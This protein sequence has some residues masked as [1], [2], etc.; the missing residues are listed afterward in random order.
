M[1]KSYS[2]QIREALSVGFKGW[3]F[4]YILESGRM[5]EE[6][7]D[8][9]YEKIVR[10]YFTRTATML[11]MGT[12]GG[13]VLSSL[14]LLPQKTYATESYVPNVEVARNKLEPLGVEVLYIPEN[15]IP[16]YS[17][18][19]P[20]EK[21]YFDLVINRHD[22]YYPKELY[23]ILKDDGYFI[24]Q[25]VGFLTVANLLKDMLGAN[26]S[27]G[28]WNLQSATDELQSEK[29]N[30]VQQNEQISF[31]RFY[32]IGAFVYYL[33]AIPWLVED[34]TP[35]K[36]DKQL[37]YIHQIIQNQGYYQTLAHRFFIIAKKS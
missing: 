4:S 31:I 26:A 32:D 14:M 6:G 8:W 35:E 17:D 25:Q 29:F 34:F 24:T 18:N 20:F 33:K 28:N 5:K 37:K 27:Y 3:D 12:G 11:D 15:K 21:N 2:E 36:Y 9:S 1:E 16:P 23:R 13:E 30:V 19:L 7:F 10:S 22:A